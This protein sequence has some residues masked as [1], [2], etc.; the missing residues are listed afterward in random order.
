VVKIKSLKFLFLSFLT[1]FS[2]FISISVKANSGPPTNLSLLVTGVTEPY[3]LDIFIYQEDS[4]SQSQID[5]ME[6]IMDEDFLD[7]HYYT[8]TYPEYLK[9]FQDRDHYVSNTLYGS[10]SNFRGWEKDSEQGYG[11]FLNVPRVFKIVLVNEN[12][13]LLI[14]E[15]IEMESYDLDI[16]WDL[17][18]V[19]FSDE[20]TY[21][22]GTLEGLGENPFYEL[23]YYVDMIVRLV[24]T[25]VIEGLVFFAFGF[26]QKRTYI[27]FAIFNAIS[28]IGLTMGT[29]YS[30]FRG[31]NAYGTIFIFFFGELAIFLAE[32][33]LLTLLVK[34]K[35]WYVRTLVTFLA[36]LLSLILGLLI[37]YGVMNLFD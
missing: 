2:I 35:K 10:V 7:G 26:R 37:S 5:Q 19:S 36:N 23:S 22:A 14:S 25:I 30:F 3:S 1:V 18:G 29:I 17:Q 34:E 11:L 9:S 8:D 32:M 33:F 16:T 12:D 6:T 20:I 27:I 15:V 31:D 28:Q 13:E 21:D 24:V 4:L